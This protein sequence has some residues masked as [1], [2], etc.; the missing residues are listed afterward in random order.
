MWIG[1]R[2]KQARETALQMYREALSA[3]GEAI[4]EF[5]QWRYANAELLALEA[6]AMLHSLRTDTQ[7][8]AARWLRIAIWR[9]RYRKH[10]ARAWAKD[11]LLAQT[12]QLTLDA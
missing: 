6:K 5:V 9:K 3:L 7:F 10:A 4:I 2:Q 11:A 8:V 12:C 1:P